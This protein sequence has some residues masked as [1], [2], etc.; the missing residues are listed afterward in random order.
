MTD[1]WAHE[2]YESSRRREKRICEKLKKKLPKE[3][4]FLQV[5]PKTIYGFSTKKKLH[6]FIKAGND[7][8]GY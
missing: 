1:N 4:Y 2:I 7:V 6:A 3:R 8:S 5:G